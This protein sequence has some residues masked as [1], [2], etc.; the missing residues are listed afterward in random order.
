MSTRASVVIRDNHNQIYLY[1]H[2]DG[3]PEGLGKTIEAFLDTHFAR[4]AK[5]DVEYMAGALVS[6]VN[7]DC[8]HRNQ[9]T[10]DLVCAV[11]VHGDEQ[12]QY[13]IDADTLKL[14]T[15]AGSGSFAYRAK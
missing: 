15:Y 5:E 14:D 10:V 4:N 6:F 3:Y 2:S 13:V 8:V 9:S 7:Y 1:Q 11:G 12:Y